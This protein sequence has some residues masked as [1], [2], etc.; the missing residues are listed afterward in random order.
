[1]QTRLDGGVN[2]DVVFAG[3]GTLA[4][5]FC[6][7]PHPIRGHSWNSREEKQ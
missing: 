2:V 5:W 1:M 7:G 4:W 6:P 3:E